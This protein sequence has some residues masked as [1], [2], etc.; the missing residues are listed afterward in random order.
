MASACGAAVWS[1]IR[2]QKLPLACP[3]TLVFDQTLR[4]VVLTDEGCSHR[5][6][7]ANYQVAYIHC[8]QNVNRGWHVQGDAVARPRMHR[9]EAAK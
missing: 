9:Q 7:P 5:Q 3:A 1:E 6:H 8:S 2:C 4:R